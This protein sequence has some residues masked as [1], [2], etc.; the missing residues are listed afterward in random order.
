MKRFALGSMLLLAAACRG[1]DDTDTG[2]VSG[3]ASLLLRNALVGENNEDPSF[4]V[5]LNEELWYEG[6]PF[7]WNANRQDLPLLGESQTFSVSAVLQS[8]GAEV[9]TQSVDVIQGDILTGLVFGD[10][11]VTEGP[12][13]P[14]MFLFPIDN[15]IPP[16][17][18]L[19]L[20]VFHAFTGYTDPV[21]I[22]YGDDAETPFISGLG[23]GQLS[24]VQR[25][26][27]PASNEGRP[28]TI[29]PAGQPKDQALG[30]FTMTPRGKDAAYLIT[31]SHFPGED[32]VAGRDERLT[33][34][35]SGDR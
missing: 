34:M 33:V 30:R 23:Y 5:F 12:T 29:V 31:L 25:G 16:A 3:Q 10:I 13:A 4:D 6:T 24:E 35:V 14:Q 11:T 22:Y 7:L 1:T 17:G 26:A 27:N 28:V 32:G 21:D 18:T 8:T 15:E 19:R 20:R 2:V 9:A